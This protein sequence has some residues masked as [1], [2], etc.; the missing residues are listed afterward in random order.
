MKRPQSHPKPL[1]TS[2]LVVLAAILGYYVSRLIRHVALPLGPAELQ[3]AEDR[4]VIPHVDVSNTELTFKSA[5][6]H[7]V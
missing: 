2:R 4:P 6:L 7:D 5:Y 3:L 1:S